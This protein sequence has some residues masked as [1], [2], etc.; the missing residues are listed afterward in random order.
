MRV[1]LFP[2]SKGPVRDNP[3]QE[4]KVTSL[5]S[6]RRQDRLPESSSNASRK[7][8]DKSR[9]AATDRSPQGR[10]LRCICILQERDSVNGEISKGGESTVPRR[11]RAWWVLSGFLLQAVGAGSVAA[12]LWTKVRHEDLGGHITTVMIRLAWHAE[13]HTRQG[14]AVLLAG[15]VVYAAGSVVAARPYITNPFSLLV[16]VPV[17]AIAGMLVLGVL[18]VVVAVI[19]FL[20]SANADLGGSGSAWGHSRR[21]ERRDAA[22]G[23]N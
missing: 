5:G 15:A 1:A 10:C 3:G 17:A 9:S 12:Y 23:S 7:V 11:N 22:S 20:A 19:V 21:R 8:I 18:A 14:L 13:V 4:A 2:V 6:L 16:A